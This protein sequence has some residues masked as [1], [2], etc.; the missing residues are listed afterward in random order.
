MFC[1][2]KTDTFGH[3][4]LVRAKPEYSRLRINDLEVNCPEK[5]QPSLFPFIDMKNVITDVLHMDL[6]VTYRFELLLRKDI[7]SMN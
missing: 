2:S 6:K 3:L 4:E 5:I 1:L 7:E